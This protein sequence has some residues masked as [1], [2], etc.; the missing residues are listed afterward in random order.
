MGKA[1]ALSGLMMYNV[2]GVRMGYH[3]VY[4]VDGVCTTVPTPRMLLSFVIVSL[5]GSFCLFS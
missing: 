5:I 4:T 3:S 2:Q 1:V